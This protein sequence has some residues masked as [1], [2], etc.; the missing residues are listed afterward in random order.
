MPSAHPCSP[1]CSSASF[2][3]PRRAP[4][5]R[6]APEGRRPHWIGRD[7]RPPGPRLGNRRAGRRPRAAG[8]RRSAGAQRHR[9][10]QPGSGLRLDRRAH[11]RLDLPRAY[12]TPERVAA[13]YE[14]LIERLSALPLEASGA[15]SS[16]LLSRLPN[17]GSINIEGRPPLR[18]ARRTF[19][20]RIDSVTPGYFATLQIPL[21]RGRMFTAADA[22][23]AQE[24]ALVN[25]SFVRRFFPNEDPLGGG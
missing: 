6:R 18:P 22:P 7:S 13:F 21:R 23:R 5:L 2:R 11:P 9:A 19:R 1:A 17:S 16:L 14:Q 24:V 8:W 25:E 3:H 20:F 12:T 15:G 10:E 4:R